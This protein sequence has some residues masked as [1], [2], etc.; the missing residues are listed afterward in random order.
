MGGAPAGASGANAN[1]NPRFKTSLCKHF[2]ETGKCNVGSKCHFAHGQHEL[3]GK[4]DPIPRDL[5]MKLMNL[6]YNNFKTQRCKYF[7][8][9]GV[10]KFS[11][12]CSF[13]HGEEELRNPFDQL[14]IPPMYPHG[15]ADQMAPSYDLKAT[16]AINENE[17]KLLVNGAND[18]EK[19]QIQT[20]LYEAYQWM[21]SGN[22]QAGYEI[23]NQLLIQGRISFQVPSDQ[24]ITNNWQKQ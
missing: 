5:Q 6:P 17:P 4:D 22:K 11:K 14:L 7:D 8:E 2:E 19:A 10:C 20:T 3:R 12:N 15:G 1:Y 21:S 13:A 9:T 18:H 23:L 16:H 24:V